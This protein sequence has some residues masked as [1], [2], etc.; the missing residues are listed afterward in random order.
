LGFLGTSRFVRGNP[1]YEGWNSL[2]FLG[3]S[4]QNR[5]LSIGYAGFSAENFSYLLFWRETP[6]RAP[7][8]EA[9]RKGG[10]VHEASLLQFLIVRKQLSSEPME[11]ADDLALLILTLTVRLFF[12]SGATKRLRSV[13]ACCSL[14]YKRN[15]STVAPPNPLACQ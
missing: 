14:A 7:A 6:E 9:I 3:F 13:A 11:R 2:D 4:P 15:A 8:V 1:F 5:D 10:I 12:K